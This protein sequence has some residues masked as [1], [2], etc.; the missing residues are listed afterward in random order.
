[1]ATEDAVFYLVRHAKAE[2]ASK[3]GDAARRLTADG[4]RRFEALARA[5]APRLGVARILTSP[6][7]R[8]RET[9]EVLAAVT[10]APVEEEPALASGRS[11]A[12]EV[13]ALA[14]AAGNGVALVGHNPELAEAIALAAGRDEMVR[15]GTVAAVEARRGG[16]V[17]AWI[18]APERAE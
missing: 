5:L 15:P 18:E 3:G 10:G 12:G 14:H 1:M 11:S 17:L 4:R 16:A 9:A 13:L 7:V 6:L 8:A 2:E